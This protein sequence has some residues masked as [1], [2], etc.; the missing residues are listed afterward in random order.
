MPD[1]PRDPRMDPKPG[2]VLKMTDG[3]TLKIETR[4]MRRANQHEYGLGGNTKEYVRYRLAA[5][6]G[7]LFIMAVS[8]FRKRAKNAEVLE[9]TRGRRERCRIVAMARS[10]WAMRLSA[11]LRAALARSEP[12]TEGDTA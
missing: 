8:G 12:K 1:K 7:S 4:E 11:D 9:K 5:H 6:C 3:H 2:D 10:N